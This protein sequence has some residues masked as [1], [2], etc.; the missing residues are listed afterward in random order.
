[1]EVLF[2]LPGHH[3]DVAVDMKILFASGKYVHDENTLC[4]VFWLDI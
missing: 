3:N 4:I 2:K 1:M